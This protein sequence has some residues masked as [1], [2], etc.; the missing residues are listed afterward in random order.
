VEQYN[1]KINRSGSITLPAALRRK[2]GINDKERFSIK[3]KDDGEIVLKRVQGECIFCKSDSDLI[4]YAGV[5][6]CQN[7]IQAL[8]AR[9]DGIW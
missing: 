1:K 6:V 2:L 4:V 5:F 3:V 8:S 9:K 7:C